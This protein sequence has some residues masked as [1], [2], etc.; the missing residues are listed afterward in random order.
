MQPVAAITECVHREATGSL[1][2]LVPPK[3]TLVLIVL[4]SC[5]VVGY[6]SGKM[7]SNYGHDQE[8]DDGEC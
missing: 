8:G 4:E 3:I 2:V 1:E 6:D 7:Y 5:D